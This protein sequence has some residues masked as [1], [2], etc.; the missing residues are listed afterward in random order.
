MAAR[1]PYDVVSAVAPAAAATKLELLRE[2]R[3]LERRTL[4]GQA[5]VVVATLQDVRHL[6]DRTRALYA[7]IAATG[8]DVTLYA[9]DLPA[10]VAE[11]VRGVGLTDDDPLVDLWSVLVDGAD[12]S[13]AFVAVDCYRPDCLDLEREFEAVRTDD[14]RVVRQCLQLLAH[15]DG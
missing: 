5:M 1:T 3:A 8:A 4:H 13:E 2:V 14:R 15:P 10:Y 9:R 12:V 7:R 6:T 11:G